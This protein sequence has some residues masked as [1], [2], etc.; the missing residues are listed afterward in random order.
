ME[1]QSVIAQMNTTAQ[2]LRNATQG[3]FKL[4]HEKAEAERIYRIELAKEIA[5]LRESKTPVSILSDL[6]RGNENVS[7]LK[8]KR[9]LAEDRY[10]S[11]IE[12][13]RGLQ[14]ELS[15]LQTISKYQSDI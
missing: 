1:L 4:A 11:G 6:A 9:D 13:I 14:S 5:R 7:L 2:R 15:A 10:K 8:F 12:V 3:I